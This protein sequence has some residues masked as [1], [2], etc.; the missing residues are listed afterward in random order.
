VKSE[1]LSLLYTLKIL[2]TYLGA[3]LT[4]GSPNSR[5]PLLKLVTRQLQKNFLLTERKFIHFFQTR[6]LL[7]NVFP[8]FQL[9]RNELRLYR[10]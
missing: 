1:S 9:S 8:A 10:G 3:A 6:F 4:K 7:G 5:S 2:L